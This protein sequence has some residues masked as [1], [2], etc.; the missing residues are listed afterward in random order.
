MKT[1]EELLQDFLEQIDQGV[2][3]ADNLAGLASEETALLQLAT[4]LRQL[5]LPAPSAGFAGQQ[6]AHLLS[7]AAKTL[8]MNGRF[9]HWLSFNKW[10]RFGFLP[11]LALL[12]V[13]LLLMYLFISRDALGDMGPGTAVSPLLTPTSTATITTTATVTPTAT[14]TPT[15][16][17]T[18]TA[19]VT[20][21][22]TATITATPTVTTTATIT[23]TAAITPTVTLTPPLPI[24]PPPSA[25]VTLCHKPNSKNPRTI[26]VDQSALPAHL[27]H[28]D[29]LGP[30]P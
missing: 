7:H 25:K 10:K 23:P 15:M 9:P 5:P 4:N 6:R 29:T 26:T 13:L 28:G 20:I 27:G 3:G 12:A 11:V 18:P 2:S 22:A 30:C 19:T 16:T 14:I 24:L 17:T 21:S 1:P 8:P